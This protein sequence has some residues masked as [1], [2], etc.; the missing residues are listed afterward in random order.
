LCRVCVR[1]RLVHSV[2][3]HTPVQRTAS[4]RCINRPGIHHGRAARRALKP[5][6]LRAEIT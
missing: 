2:I 3:P 5:S 6:R 1:R 4:R